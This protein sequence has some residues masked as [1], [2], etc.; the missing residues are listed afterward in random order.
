MG[1]VIDVAH[2]FILMLLIKTNR[3]HFASRK[4]KDLFSIAFIV[5]YTYN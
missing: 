1:D 4:V 5:R 2:I 3:T